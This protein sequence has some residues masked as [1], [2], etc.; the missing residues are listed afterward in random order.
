MDIS[1]RVRF[2]PWEN[3][4][5]SAAMRLHHRV[6]YLQLRLCEMEAKL[7]RVQG[8]L[9]KWD[10]WYYDWGW[11][12]WRIRNWWLGTSSTDTDMDDKEITM[13]TG[14]SKPVI[15]ETARQVEL[16]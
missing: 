9:D 7:N 5:S 3:N 13:S 2:S 12:L 10:A 8:N 1:N 11:F 4:P 15:L 14:V 6:A 16:S